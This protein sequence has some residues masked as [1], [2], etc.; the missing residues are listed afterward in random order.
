MLCSTSITNFRNRRLEKLMSRQEKNVRAI[1]YGVFV[2]IIFLLA[3]KTNEKKLIRDIWSLFPRT[4]D[5]VE[6][7]PSKANV[8]CFNF[9]LLQRLRRTR[10]R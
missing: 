7:R 9:F 4:L 5:Q 1:C 3:C 8:L 2:T 10:E 6:R